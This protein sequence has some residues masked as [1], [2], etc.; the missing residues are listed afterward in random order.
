MVPPFVSYITW[1]RMGLTVRNLSG[2]LETSDDFEL[3]IVDNNSQDNTWDYLQE[4][5]DPRIKSKTRLVSNKGPIY[6]VNYNLAKRKKD[7]YFITIDSDVYI[8]TKNWVTKF[9]EVFESFPEVGLLGLPR[10]K[11]YAGYL[12]PVLLNVKDG[13]GY[14]QLKNGSLRDPLDFVPGHLQCLRPEL[15]EIIGYWSEES[16]T[17][18]KE[19]SARVMHYTPFK[20]GYVTTIEIDQVQ[21]VCCEEC[22]AKKWCRLDIRE[23]NCNLIREKLYYNPI[24]SAT[25]FWKNNQVFKELKEGTRTA[26]CASI[27]DEKSM[28]EHIY[29]RNWAEENFRFF[30]EHA[31]TLNN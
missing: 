27:H 3:H 17:G 20:V 28:E 13:T 22:T 15:I 29:N 5:R 26:F 19:M 8:Y 11:P 18:D 16:H 31:N 21:E 1:N 4:L 12:P 14:L 10:A 30:E 2:L 9:M 25:Y 24:F 6:A 7:Q 23:T